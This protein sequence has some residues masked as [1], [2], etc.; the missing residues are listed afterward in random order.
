[1]LKSREISP[2]LARHVSKGSL[3]ASHIFTLCDTIFVGSSR[4]SVGR[5]RDYAVGLRGLTGPEIAP[6]EQHSLSLRREGLRK[7]EELVRQ[8][9]QSYRQFGAIG[10]YS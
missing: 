9:Q 1:M 3:R 5:Y 6:G 2:L 4:W 7:Y 8:I 10:T